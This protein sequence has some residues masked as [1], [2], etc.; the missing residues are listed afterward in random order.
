MA[1]I[2]NTAWSPDADITAQITGTGQPTPGY[3]GPTTIG[4]GFTPVY[5][6]TIELS[7]FLQKSRFILLTTTSGVGNATLT[8]LFVP[9]AGCQLYIQ[10][11]NDAG[12]ARTITFT[13]GFRTTA[14][15]VGTA[16]KAAIIE[17]TSDGT[18]WNESGRSLVIN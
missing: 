8:T 1:G 10:I 7:P 4:A 3:N 13:T 18:T 9:S 14:T 2:K 12:A 17:F 6:A 5:A 16:S 11:N 15:V